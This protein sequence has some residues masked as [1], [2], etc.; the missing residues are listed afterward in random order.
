MSESTKAVFVSYA[1]ED[2]EAAR[3]I[4]DALK[5]FEVEVWF[6]EAGLE[7]GDAWDQKIRGQIKECSLFIPIISAQ[8]QARREAYFRLEWKLAEERTHLMAEGTAFLLPIVIDETPEA[9][10]LVPESF[11][12]MQ[13]TKLPHGVPNIPFVDRVRALLESQRSHG[14]PSVTPGMVPPVRPR[15][16]WPLVAVGL[17]L[18]VGASV[19]F[20]S[21]KPAPPAAAVVPAAADKSIAVLPFTNMS[22]DKE[23]AYFADGMHEDL[24]TQLAL[25]GDLK[26]T[27]RTSVAEY[28][29]TRKKVRQIGAELGVATLLEGSVRRSGDRVRVTAQLIDVQSDR[30]LWAK[31]YDRDLKDVFAI[32]A[33]LAAEIAQSLQATLSPQI[34]VELARIPTRNMV[35]YELLLRQQATSRES[36]DRP[37]IDA[38]ID[39]LTQAVKLDPG[40]AIAW[41]RLG[42]MH[43][44][45]IFDFQD[46]SPERLARAQAAIN[47]AL[48]LAP[49]VPEVRLELGNFYYYALRD[50]AKAEAIYG[51]ILTI[52]P[53]HVEVLAQT[54]YVLRREGRFRESNAYLEKVLALD[55]RHLRVLGNLYYNFMR[56]RDYPGAIDTARRMI[57]LRPL[58]LSYQVLLQRAGW[59]KNR[60]ATTYEVWRAQQAPGVET[61]FRPLAAMDFNL[62]L[63]RRDFA[64][65]ERLLVVLRDKPRSASLE[66]MFW[67]AKGDVQAARQTAEFALAD[68]QEILRQRPTDPAEWAEVAL[69]HALLGDKDAAW[70][71]YRR[72][73]ELLPDTRD[74]FTGANVAAYGV[75]LHALMGERAEV[76]AGLRQ[77]V[78]AAPVFS[79][80]FCTS[81]DLAFVTLWDD[82]EFK[83][84]VADPANNAPLQ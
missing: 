84:I 6:D 57:A 50:Y 79:Y 41:A 8:T 10:A 23:N 51:E 20:W 2:A 18:A 49:T 83:A 9:G 15:K 21:T 44:R 56:I 1:R 73:C 39:L 14:L 40:F 70:Q 27:S 54:G 17:V 71:E 74:A 43:A 45:Q 65:A 3:R 81:T 22:D 32:Q 64:A 13:W 38:L 67:R 78:R 24:L 31:T 55:P 58:D 29:E 61:K 11:R 34:R 26:V 4:A 60:D 68:T 53:H 12:R 75:R 80:A 66:A 52:A 72:A 19:P 47:R 48:E 46:T 42:T 62:A 7:G 16:K 77:T 82:P 30:H 5:A 33:E 59:M 36:V 28:R 63:A 25:I 37:D 76:F 35:A 69:L